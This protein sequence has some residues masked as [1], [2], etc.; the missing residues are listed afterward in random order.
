MPAVSSKL[1]VFILPPPMRVRE[2]LGRGRGI[3]VGGRGR[4]RDWRY[5]FLNPENGVV[6]K[7]L[8]T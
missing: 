8:S 3:V 5:F 4:V 7:V 2:G 1:L 6:D